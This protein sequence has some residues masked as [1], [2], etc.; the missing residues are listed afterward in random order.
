MEAVHSTNGWSAP[1][2]PP[3][4]GRR[5][6]LAP[7][8]T[9][10]VPQPQRLLAT[11]PQR[12]VAD[13]VPLDVE[14]L[15]HAAQH[16]RH[17]T[18]TPESFDTRSGPSTAELLT[19]DPTPLPATPHVAPAMPALAGGI[20]FDDDLD[21]TLDLFAPVAGT[22]VVGTNVAGAA[23]VDARVAATSV[24]GPGRAG[25]APATTD[26]AAA[27]LSSMSSTRSTLAVAPR[28]A[29]L[30]PLTTATAADANAAAHTVAA[31]D[32]A[33][34][35]R[36]P[37]ATL[38]GAVLAFAGVSVGTA[39]WVQQHPATPSAA[40]VATVSTSVPVTTAAPAI[41]GPATTTP[42]VATASPAPPPPSTAVAVTQ[43]ITP[44]SS[45]PATTEAPA[46]TVAEPA[47]TTATSVL[48]TTVLNRELL[49]G[50][51][52]GTLTGG[53][54]WPKA[55]FVEGRIVLTGVVPSEQ[56]QAVAV[57]TA[58][59]LL[60][61]DAVVNQLTIDPSAQSVRYLIVA[62][63]DNPMFDRGSSKIRKDSEPVFELWAQRLRQKVGSTVLLLAHGDGAGSAGSSL[64]VSRAKA[65][66]ARLMASEGVAADRFQSVGTAG[67][68]TGPRL[69]FAVPMP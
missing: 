21:A 36:R 30:T 66:G 61:P 10:A 39:T 19:L 67:A 59:G 1:A 57:A 2:A 50:L 3:A 22:T 18:V 40:P 34:P 52:Q 46:T 8:Q 60:T 48:G 23:V 41:A 69:D 11:P 7:G 31:L 47:T 14:A 43:A 32:L 56:D 13:A 45:L 5:M 35:R 65:A 9:L 12:V 4:D 49:D 27:A 58:G 29:V 55:S 44:A 64:A 20:A 54:A 63:F 37:A 33:P 24:A 51:G 42:V 15:E 26:L 16:A 28:P 68:A 17:R 6:T 62:L 53:Q 38:V 25:N